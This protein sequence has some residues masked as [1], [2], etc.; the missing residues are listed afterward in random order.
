MSDGEIR[1]KEQ[2]FLISRKRFIVLSLAFEGITEID[3]DTRTLRPQRDSSAKETYCLLKFWR[4]V[5]QEGTGQLMV[6]PEIRRK[7]PLS[8]AQQIDGQRPIPFV[9]Q[10]RRQRNHGRG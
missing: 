3:I 5:K 9:D 6:D 10:L 2:C 4:S 7:T 8:P 1:L